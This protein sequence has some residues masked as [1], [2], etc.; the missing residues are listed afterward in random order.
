MHD[1]PFVQ[2]GKKV[3]EPPTQARQEWQIFVDLAIAMR[4]PLF[5][6]R[7]LNA[8]V[9]ATRRAAA[10][11]RRPALAFGPHWLDRLFVRMSRKFNGHR[12]TWRELMRHPHGMV[13]GP[14][15]FGHFRDALRTD[16]KR[17]HVAPPEFVARARELLAEPVVVA[18]LDYPFTLGNRRSRHSMNSWLNELPGLHPA[19]KGNDVLINPED[20]AALGVADG[21]RVRVF[22][23]AGSIELAAELSDRL[24]RGHVVVDHGW[25]SR[26]FDPRGGGEPQSFGVNRNLLVG[27]DIDPLSQTSAMGST[28]VGVERL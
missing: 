24:R 16:D 5:G 18:P 9:T 25:G 27:D 11:T 26:I 17:V 22:S 3:V 19:G 1:E 10:V 13:L 14:R 21:D 12:L 15:E 8:F 20:A 23:P 4:K 7:G 2:Y 6:L 28:F